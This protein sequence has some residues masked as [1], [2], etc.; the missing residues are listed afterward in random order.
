MA[1]PQEKSENIPSKYL[2]FPNSYLKN[3]TILILIREVELSIL[4]Y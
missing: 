3:S 4:R 1:N 2:G